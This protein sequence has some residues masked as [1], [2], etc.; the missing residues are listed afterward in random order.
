MSWG[1]GNWRRGAAAKMGRHDLQ[2]GLES[3][4]DDS[5]WWSVDAFCNCIDCVFWRLRALE[6]PI[7]GDGWR[8]TNPLLEPIV[9]DDLLQVVAVVLGTITTDGADRVVEDDDIQAFY[10]VL[11]AAKAEQ[12]RRRAAVG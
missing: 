11:D 6:W 3:F 10:N 9:D 12:A 4:E 7:R 1:R 5:V 8:L 2:A